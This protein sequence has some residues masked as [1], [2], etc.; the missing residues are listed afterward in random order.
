MAAA[1]LPAAALGPD[2]RVQQ[3]WWG[4]TALYAALATPA[5][6]A[7]AP[8]VLQ[9]VHRLPTID[10][11]RQFFPDAVGPLAATPLGG[12]TEWEQWHL[13][14]VGAQAA[15]AYRATQSLD[16]TAADVLVLLARKGRF[17]ARV[18]VRGQE[19]TP[20]A[21]SLDAGLPVLRQLLAR[22]SE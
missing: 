3:E 12:A 16:G 4:G 7:A 6:G 5:D 13:D 17:I 1:V 2:Y 20:T 22:L 14:L 21:P 11:A 8:A 10:A 15:G 9:L 18:E 19:G